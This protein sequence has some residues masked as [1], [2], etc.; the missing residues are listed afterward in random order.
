MAVYHP[1]MKKPPRK[2][3][4]KPLPPWMPD[5]FRSSEAPRPGR[6]SGKKS[7]SVAA[8]HQTSS[9]RRAGP[10]EFRDPHAGREAQRYD[11]PITSREAILAHLAAHNKWLGNCCTTARSTM[12]HMA[13]HLCQAL[14]M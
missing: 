8:P 11:N 1:G 13:T 4:G 5:V 7:S 9:P 6:P 3:G 14:R 10:P 2:A 12:A